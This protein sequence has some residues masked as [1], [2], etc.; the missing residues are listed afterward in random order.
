MSTLVEI[1]K[2]D[3]A[4]TEL[5]LETDGVIESDQIEAI[6]DRWM[7]EIRSNLALKADGYAFKKKALE[8][9]AELFKAEAEA[10]KAASKT[11]IDFAE[12]LKDRMKQVMIDMDQPQI[13]GN[14]YK[15]SLQQ[16]SIS[17]FIDDENLIPAIYTRQKVTVEIDKDSI[18]KAIQQ[19]IKVP[20]AHLERGINLRTTLRKET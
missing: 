1:L 12:R 11:M 4:L 14:L 9:R 6:V 15:F 7:A 2:E 16:G 18:K 5:M 10:F 3:Q 17:V 20:G 8:R 13:D 19:G